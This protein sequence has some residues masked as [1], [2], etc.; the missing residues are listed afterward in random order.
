MSPFKEALIVSYDGGGDDGYFNIYS[1][2]ESKIK[3]LKSVIGVREDGDFGGGYVLFGSFIREVSE[4][5]KH[6]L[7]ISGKLMGLCGYGKPN[8]KLVPAFCWSQS[9]YHY[10]CLPFAVR[11]SQ[12]AAISH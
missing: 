6:V 12:A 5:S 2:N 7:A 10:C 4:K 8:Y 9:A 3:L 11:R 1:A